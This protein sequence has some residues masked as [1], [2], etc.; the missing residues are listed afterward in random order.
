MSKRHFFDPIAAT[1]E[2]AQ[3]LCLLLHRYAAASLARTHRLAD[4]PRCMGVD[5]T[6][7]AKWATGTRMPDPRM[8]V[9]LL[10][11]LGIPIEAWERPP[12]SGVTAPT[13]VLRD[14]KPPMT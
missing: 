5:P 7:I 2:G 3:I 10:E 14:A 6:A 8:R 4:S 9:R 13:L 12:R 1:S 11:V